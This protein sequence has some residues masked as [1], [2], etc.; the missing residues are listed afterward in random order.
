VEAKV[1]DDVVLFIAI[2]S[3][4]E[5]GSQR[6]LRALER[7]KLRPGSVLLK[8]FRN[9]ACSDL[10]ALFPNVRVVMSKL[11]KL[12]LGLPALVGGIPILLNLYAT[13]TVLFLVIGFYLGLSAT[14]HDTDMKTALAA[15]S[16]LVALGAFVVRQWVKYQRQSLRYRTELA[17]TVY[18]RNVNNNAGIFDYMIGAAEEQ[19]SKEAILVYYFLNA[20]PSPPNEGELEATIE[21]WLH[22]TFGVDLNFKVED[23]LNK[24]EQLGV[25]RRDGG[26]LFVSPFDGA[27]A[28]LRNVWDS[29][30]PADGLAG[31]MTKDLT[32]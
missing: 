2:K 3:P 5:I 27:V 22:Q 13:I 4:A 6:Q 29:W 21:A 32:R 12:S 24:L 7:R 8:Y 15:L 1:Y 9:V 25:V 26:R 23:A 31:A 10:H 14:A 17:D 30:F 16:G 11:D 19:E 20:A 18:Y 28:Q